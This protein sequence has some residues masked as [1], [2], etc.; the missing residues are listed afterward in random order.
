MSLI[1]TTVASACFFSFST[2][3]SCI[4]C[5]FYEL[6]K[7]KGITIFSSA[8]VENSRHWQ[9]GTI[10]AIWTPR[11]QLRAAER[12]RKLISNINLKQTILMM[13]MMVVMMPWIAPP[14]AVWGAPGT[15]PRSLPAA[16][17][18]T[19]M[20]LHWR[21]CLLYRPRLYPDRYTPI[22]CIHNRLGLRFRRHDLRLHKG[23]EWAPLTM[24][25]SGVTQPHNAAALIQLHDMMNDLLDLL[26][27]AV[28]EFP[29][30]HRRQLQLERPVDEGGRERRHRCQVNRSTGNGIGAEG[31]TEWEL[32]AEGETMEESSPV[33]EDIPGPLG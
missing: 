14:V 15:T 6:S 20:F 13:M 4:F 2:I 25:V 30:L 23:G 1:F 3:I 28:K 31:N 21:R 7:R 19:P 27:G 17:G 12:T 33:V 8:S 10:L 11:E 18:M 29:P 26:S 24:W 22:S 32:L 5:R 16:M 9:A